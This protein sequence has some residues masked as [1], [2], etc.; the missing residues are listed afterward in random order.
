M[1]SGFQFLGLDWSL[2]L[3]S[4][5]EW[6]SHHHK[7]HEPWETDHI[8]VF[9]SQSLPDWGVGVSS[10][11]ACTMGLSSVPPCASRPKVCQHARELSLKCLSFPKCSQRVLDVL[12]AKMWCHCARWLKTHKT[13]PMVQFYLKWWH[14]YCFTSQV[15]AY[16]LC[17]LSKYLQ[18]I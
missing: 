2:C 15:M 10:L 18:S 7:S 8:C 3:D 9:Q 5:S 14:F 1:G 13:V 4:A 6:Y 17:V 12:K 11:V 16:W